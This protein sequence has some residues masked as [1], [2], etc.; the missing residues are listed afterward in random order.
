MPSIKIAVKALKYLCLLLAKYLVLGEG[1]LFAQL[2]LDDEGEAQAEQKVRER[3]VED[4]DVSASPHYLVG[5][6][7][8]ENHHVVHNY[9]FKIHGNIMCLSY[10]LIGDVCLSVLGVRGEVSQARP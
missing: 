6:H 5:H 3:E 4:K 2:V 10:I 8:N 9:D 1:K 7:G